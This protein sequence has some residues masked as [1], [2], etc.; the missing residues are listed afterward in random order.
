M[1]TV[2]IA[3]PDSRQRVELV[4]DRSISGETAPKAA[5]MEFSDEPNFTIAAVTDWTAAGGHGSDASLRTSEVLN[6]DTAALGPEEKQ[7]KP[8]GSM[9]EQRAMEGA[10]LAAATRTPGSFEANRKLGE[11]YL[12]AERF[13][14]S[15]GPLETAYKLDSANFENEFDLSRA[16]LGH[17]DIGK[18]R[19][20]LR[21]LMS[22]SDNAALHRLAGEI[23]EKLG[24][25]LDAVHEFERAVHIDP[26]EQNYFSWGSE[27]LLHRA[28][29]QAKDVFSAGVKSYPRS[30]RMLTAVGAAL[31][32]GAL[33]DDAARRLCEASDLSP[34]DPEPHLFMGK[35]EMAAPNPLPCVDE[36]LER[37]AEHRP[38]DPLANYFYAMAVWKRDPQ[39]AKAATLNHVQDLLMKAVVLDPNCSDAYFQLGVLHAERRDYEQAINFYHK[40]I[41]ANPQMPEAHY[42]LGMAYDRIGKQEEARHE[43]QLHDEI[44]KQQAAQVEQARREVKQF[45]VV[46]DGKAKDH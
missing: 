3:T 18:A 35:I 11:F 34:D 43:F 36:K 13:Q 30:V 23:D 46:V 33:Y 29:W 21:N 24:D 22:H 44:Q 5:P 42:R 17:G 16:L 15:I 7:A 19:E 20:H 28:I 31:F 45:L 8:Q 40:A 2:N 41:A 37:F 38:N 27:L 1:V 4:L 14:D 9:G 12:H 25:P 32:A 10:L 26:S 39:G 6:R